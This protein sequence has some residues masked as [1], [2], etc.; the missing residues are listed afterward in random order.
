[1]IVLV[2]M[3]LVVALIVSLA[4]M[5]R[6]DVRKSATELDLL[7]ARENALMGMQVA[8]G[9]LQS[10]AGPDQRITAPAEAVAGVTDGRKQVLGVWRSWEGRNHTLTG[11]DQ[12]MPIIPDYASKLSAGDQDPDSTQAGRFLGWLSSDAVGQR[13]ATAPPTLEKSNDT[14]PLLRADV[15]ENEVHVTPTAIEVNSSG[16]PTGHYAWWI[17]G[18]NT[19]ALVTH[20]EGPD[21]THDWALHNATFN[22]ADPSV[23][24]LEDVAQI[25]QIASRGG[26]D[27]LSTANTAGTPQRPSKQFFHDLTPWSR[28]LLTNAATGGWKRDLSLATEDWQAIPAADRSFF[29]VRPGE[30]T[31]APQLDF[32]PWEGGY[33]EVQRG[34][35]NWSA[36]QDF[37]IQYRNLNETGSGG[38][39]SML[40]NIYPVNNLTRRR[41]EVRR[42]PVV[43]RIHLVFSYSSIPN[44]AP[45]A[46]P[47]EA[48]TACLDVN[49]VV[50]LWNP[51]NVELTI[52]ALSMLI[53][54][55]SDAAFHFSVDRTSGG[56]STTSYPRITMFQILDNQ[57]WRIN[58]VNESGTGQI[59]LQP[60][61]AR[62]FSPQDNAPVSGA[63]TV[64]LYPG[65][66]T[67]GGFRYDRLH[68]IGTV[69]NPEM[70]AIRAGNNDR[71]YTRLERSAD[72]GGTDPRNRRGVGFSLSNAQ[73]GAA[74]IASFSENG[75]G[76]GGF[77]A[78]VNPAPSDGP[79]GK[80]SMQNLS[81]SP[82]P[83]YASYIS[84]DAASIEPPP[85][86]DAQIG[87][88]LLGNNPLSYWTRG[89][90]GINSIFHI[91]N[92]ALNG[93]NGGIGVPE[94]MERRGFIGATHQADRGLTHLPLVELPLRPLRSL[95]ELQ[96]C[97]I[98]T[99]RHPPYEFNAIGNSHAAF[100]FDPSITAP[101]RIQFFSQDNSVSNSGYSY[102][103]GYVA[104][105]LLFDDWFVSSIAPQ[106]AAWTANEVRSKTEVYRDHMLRTEPLPNSFYQPSVLVDDAD[107]DARVVEDIGRADSWRAIASKLVVTGMFNVNSTSVS[108]WTA[109]L[110]NMRDARVPEFGYAPDSDAW[111][112]EVGDA[113]P[114]QTS[115]TRASVAGSGDAS[116]SNNPELGHYAPLTDTQIDA[117]AT[118]IVNQ[119]KKRGPFLSLSEFVNRQLTTSNTELARAGTID[120]ALLTLSDSDDVS[121][122]PNAELQA[123]F[124]TRTSTG[125]TFESFPEA[126]QGSAVYGY[127]GWVRQADILRS[128]APILS[129]RD[130]TFVIR[131]Y[132]D[133]R[134]PT[135]GNIVSRA[136]CEA[137][138]QRTGDFV[139]PADDPTILPGTATLKSD[140]NARFGRRFRIVS[141]RW[142]T[143]DEV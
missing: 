107:I 51:Y 12:G 46:P 57:P 124:P 58:F 9:N 86:P 113:N 126:G 73:S 123:I 38:A 132:G 44:P 64:N 108:A 114:A 141:F 24:D 8:L 116:I 103:S 67:N 34:A 40:G 27:L 119:I 137:V 127:P 13:D 133:Y 61:E 80:L 18:E 33:A 28:G 48:F 75:A 90:L 135:N 96:H 54:Q 122:N 111:A 68:N 106:T 3:A 121:A 20:N 11:A 26:F 6:L 81:V 39:P 65:Y 115:F 112:I 95:A 139:D 82:D 7:R 97:D 66:R 87:K 19:K 88:G 134:N 79:A 23:F 94:A 4:A 130:D 29:T 100:F 35:A 1:M 37:A 98:S 142:L 63:T 2:L 16:N 101:A 42:Y 131:S 53:T 25:N 102:D 41:N 59:T 91:K 50:T 21:T 70:V 129:V 5:V 105:H 32:F 78:L 136:W 83:F 49:P 69:S 140:T 93:V 138:V 85:P 43:A 118:E 62:L 110:R 52:D 72:Y 109:I 89:N 77:Y 84:L 22:R 10:L 60:G 47:E 125:R 14:V 117:L 17:S 45:T 15:A 120:A 31:P 104:N 143:P 55:P 56:S 99:N 76:V 36:V 74:S 30:E 71:F 92:F 128:L